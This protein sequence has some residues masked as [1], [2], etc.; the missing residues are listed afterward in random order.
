MPLSVRGGGHE[1]VRNALV[2]RSTPSF[3]KYFTEAKRLESLRKNVEAARKLW[4]AVT[5]LLC[6]D[7]K[8]VCVLEVI[9]IEPLVS[10]AKILYCYA[11]VLPEDGFKRRWKKCIE[12]FNK[13]IERK[14]YTENE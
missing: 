2:S 3:H 11:D 14:T 4:G 9:S 12:L 8:E 7:I 5:A 6:S 13:V 10:H 1:D